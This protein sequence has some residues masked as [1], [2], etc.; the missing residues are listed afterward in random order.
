MGST[1]KLNFLKASPPI[2]SNRSSIVISAVKRQQRQRMASSL[3]RCLSCGGFGLGLV[4]ADDLCAHC[5]SQSSSSSVSSSSID[6]P[7]ATGKRPRPEY[8]SEA[9]DSASAAASAV[10]SAAQLEARE[11]AR[12]IAAADAA[13]VP[14]LDATGV[15]KMLLSLEK[16]INKNSLQRAK[17]TDE[18]ARFLDS[19]LELDEELKRLRVL[20]AAPDQFHTLVKSDSLKSLLSLLAHENSDISID[21]ITLLAELTDSSSIEGEE[22]AIGLLVDGL[23]ADGGI[24]LLIQNLARLDASGSEEDTQGIYQTF[25][26]IENM[27]EIRPLLAAA[28]C[29]PSLT[30]TPLLAFLLRKLRQKS[31][32]ANKLYASELLV[33]LLQADPVNQRTIGAS[34]FSLTTASGSHTVDGVELLL[35][36]LNQYKKKAVASRD[37][38]E[39]IE[40]TFDALCTCMVRVYYN[41][42]AMRT[43]DLSALCGSRGAIRGAWCEYAVYYC[44]FDMTA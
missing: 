13:E 19:E 34:S 32:D 27:V 6:R 21:V 22:A 42:Y 16:K 18:P 12:L 24:E 2:L 25:S 41:T 30:K 3:S 9:A 40:N 15:K 5:R 38:E 31:F 37:E 20:A 36:A 35:E 28:L 10:A 39:C 43:Y 17:Y 11:V 7:H 14:T 8:E 1:Q 44:T 26:L 33:I 29:D 4:G 23:V